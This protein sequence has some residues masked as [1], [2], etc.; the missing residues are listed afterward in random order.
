[1]FYNDSEF[2]CILWLILFQ[3]WLN[4]V[5]SRVNDLTGQCQ[6]IALIKRYHIVLLAVTELAGGAKRLEHFGDI[7]TG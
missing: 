3:L 7:L 2:Q 1:M 5:V 4:C 6:C